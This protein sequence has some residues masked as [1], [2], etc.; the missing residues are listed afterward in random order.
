MALPT[1]E[2]DIDC[3]KVICSCDRNCFCFKKRDCVCDPLPSV[4]SLLNLDISYFDEDESKEEL[5]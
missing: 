2:I 5:E 4:E 3:S 1:I